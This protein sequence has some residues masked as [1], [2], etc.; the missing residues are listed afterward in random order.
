MMAA[1]MEEN[2]ATAFRQSYRTVQPEGR[3]G[4]GRRSR[5][6]RR[7]AARAKNLPA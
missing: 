3:Y 7:E 1:A 4:G 2:I 6:L 5:P